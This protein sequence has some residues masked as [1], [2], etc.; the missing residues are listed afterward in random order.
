MARRKGSKVEVNLSPEVAEI[1]QKIKAFT[2]NDEQTI[3]EVM[4][5]VYCYQVDKAKV[6]E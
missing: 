1:V 5:A 3:L 6:K 2:V 4:I